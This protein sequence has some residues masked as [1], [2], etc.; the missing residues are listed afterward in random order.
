VN[1]SSPME[2]GRGGLVVACS[3]ELGW[4]M[5]PYL[6]LPPSQQPTIL[7]CAGRAT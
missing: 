4:Q 3:A 2:G 7:M 6:C 5:T 1:S